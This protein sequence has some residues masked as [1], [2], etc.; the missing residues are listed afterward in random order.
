MGARLLT[1]LPE[2]RARRHE[3]LTETVELP[4]AGA[5]KEVWPAPRRARYKELCCS[6]GLASVPVACLEVFRIRE[7][8]S[9]PLDCL[10]FGSGRKIVSNDCDRFFEKLHTQVELKL[11]K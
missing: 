2:L 5:A 10:R 1:P 6:R 9:K 11:E 4:F 8:S 7:G 3:S